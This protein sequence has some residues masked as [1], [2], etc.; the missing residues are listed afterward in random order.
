MKDAAAAFDFKKTRLGVVTMLKAIPNDVV[1]S[2]I[3]WYLG[4]GFERCWLFFDDRVSRN[5]AFKQANPGYRRGTVRRL[6]GWLVLHI[7]DFKL[8]SFT[9]ACA[10]ELYLDAA[11]GSEYRDCLFVCAPTGDCGEGRVIQP[12]I[13][14]QPHTRQ[15]SRSILSPPV[16]KKSGIGCNVAN[17]LMRIPSGR[18]THSTK[19]AA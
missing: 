14:L 2:W 10:P 7:D 1:R 12:A 17:F 18:I 15:N 5:A 6:V 13:E 16:N 11:L 19:A 4:L 8:A 9:G 3:E